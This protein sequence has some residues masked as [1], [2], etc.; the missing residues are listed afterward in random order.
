MDRQKTETIDVFIEKREKS[1]RGGKSPGGKSQ[2]FSK[3]IKKDRTGTLLHY[4][5]AA[6][7]KLTVAIKGESF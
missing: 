1:R 5:D 3:I 4:C 7:I 6:R 2:H